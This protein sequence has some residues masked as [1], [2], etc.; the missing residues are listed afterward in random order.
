MQHTCKDATPCG[1]CSG[2]HCTDSCSSGAIRCLACGEAHF[3]WSTKCSKRHTIGASEKAAKHPEPLKKN[4]QQPQAAVVDARELGRPTTNTQKRK[5]DCKISPLPL[6]AVKKTTDGENSADHPHSDDRVG[7]HDENGRGA[8]GRPQ[9]LQQ[10]HRRGYD[11]PARGRKSSSPNSE[12][13]Q[14]PM[15][16][17][18]TSFLRSLSYSDVTKVGKN[19]QH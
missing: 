3:V 13:T 4:Q 9:Q 7:D 5:Q 10:R 8:E 19:K 1:K 16:R 18:S 6:P 17:C 2:K 12:S 15:V 11:S 14:V